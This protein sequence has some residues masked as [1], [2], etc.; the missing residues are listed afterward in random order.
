M[1]IGNDTLELRGE[2]EIRVG[3]LSTP[4][5]VR[6]FRRKS[7][8]TF[9]VQQSHFVRTSI[10][11]LPFAINQTFTCEQEILPRVEGPI[12]HWYDQAVRRGYKPSESWLVPNTNFEQ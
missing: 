9:V 4:I 7:D 6:V 8:G 1:T 10:Q 12:K 3:D 2:H 11:Y 5:R